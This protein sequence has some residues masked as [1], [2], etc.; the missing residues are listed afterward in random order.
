LRGVRERGTKPRRLADAFQGCSV[1][2]F[3]T[4]AGVEGTALVS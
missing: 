2:G 3:F 1:R 4:T